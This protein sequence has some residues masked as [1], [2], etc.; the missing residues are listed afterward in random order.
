[1]PFDLGDVLFV[2]LP[3]SPVIMLAMIL[4]ANA[5]QPKP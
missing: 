3:I 2:L 5:A 1:M 4:W